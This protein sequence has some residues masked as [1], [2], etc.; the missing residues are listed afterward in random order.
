[1]CATFDQSDRWDA[2]T[3]VQA[4]TDQKATDQGI[5]AP[6]TTDQADNSPMGYNCPYAKIL[7][8]NKGRQWSVL[9]SSKIANL[10]FGI[11]KAA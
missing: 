5:T 8:E 1:M 11:Q 9:L 10:I 2:P 7:Q 4:P 3:S 6:A